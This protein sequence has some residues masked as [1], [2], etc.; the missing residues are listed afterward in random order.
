[1]IPSLKRLWR[2]IATVMVLI[3]TIAGFIYYFASHPQVRQQLHQTSMLTLL[4]LF[5]LYLLV[6][7]A[8]SMVTLTTLRLCNIRLA[9]A[10]STLLTMYASVINFFG[11]LQSGPAFRGVY[12]KRKHGL[13]LKKYTLAT[14]V[15]YGLYALF[16]GI[17]LLSGI[18]G[19]WLLI[20]GA[21]AVAALAYVRRSNQP[22]L[23]RF[24]ALNLDAIYALAAATLF[25]VGLVAVIYF[26]ELRSISPG[27][28]FS[29]AVIYA[30]AANFSLFVSLT[31]GAIGFRESFLLFSQRLHHISSSTIVAANIIDRSMYIVLLAVIGLI[32]FGTHAQH[33]LDSNSKK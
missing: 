8:L 20:G 12:L 32:I 6:L 1:M 27:V 2:P 16:S 10:E 9:P 15:F 30:G 33:R 17:F 31:P 21:F 28:H 14:L 7:V 19:W 23:Q 18:L 3:V 26:V 24:Q 29:Q 4:V 22:L 5:G 11:P 13:D 25:Q